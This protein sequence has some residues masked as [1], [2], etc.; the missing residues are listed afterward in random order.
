MYTFCRF[1]DWQV[2]TKLNPKDDFTVFLRTVLDIANPFDSFVSQREVRDFIDI[3]GPRIETEKAFFKGL[4]SVL[5]NRTLSKYIPIVGPAGSGKTHFFWFLKDQEEINRKKKENSDW[6]AIYVPAPLSSDRIY[7]HLLAC[8][9]EARGI[10]LFEDVWANVKKI[11]LSD[12]FDELRIDEAFV[13]IV[14]RIPTDNSFLQALVI[15]G[16]DEKRRPLAE[17]YLLGETLRESEW[18]KLEIR[19]VE[20]TEERAFSIIKFLSE[21]SSVRNVFYYDELESLE[22]IRGIQEME[23]LAHSILKLVEDCAGIII[24]TAALPSIWQTLGR[25]LLYSPIVRESQIA[26]LHSFSEEEFYQL[27]KETIQRWWFQHFGEVKIKDVYYP[28]GQPLLMEIHK[29]GQGNPRA[30]IRLVRDQIISLLSIERQQILVQ[31]D[32]LLEDRIVSLDDM[33]H[34]LETFITITGNGKLSN[35]Y[36]EANFT[37]FEIQKLLVGIQIVSVKHF[38]KPGG[39]SAVYAARKSVKALSDGYQ[40]IILVVSKGT[41]TNPKFQA[42]LHGFEKQ[43]HV[44]EISHEQAKNL[45]ENDLTSPILAPFLDNIRE[46]LY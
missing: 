36:Q 16:M 20:D 8:L 38:D 23:E 3:P 37:T 32:R 11:Y 22:R 10:E 19:P 12:R 21:I 6:T 29:K 44:I 28:V 43:I 15:F 30:C 7:R 4:T 9:L 41:A 24:V 26:Y 2:S 42:A 5:R 1:E 17:R 39:I 40:R 13:N 14:K 34:S 31:D 25:I 45:S 27:Y 35:R 18:K 46:I 33:L